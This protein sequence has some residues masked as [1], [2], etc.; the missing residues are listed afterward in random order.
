MSA[1]GDSVTQNAKTTARLLQDARP[2]TAI[3]TAAALG[4][5]AAV[6]R[7]L[8]S[9]SALAQ[10]RTPNGQTP[11]HLAAQWGQLEV[12]RLLLAHGAGAN[13]RDAESRTPLH[14][15][16]GHATRLDLLD[17]LIAHGADPTLSI[18]METRRS[19][20]PP[21]SSIMSATTGARTTGWLRRCSSTALGSMPSLPSSLI[22]T[23]TCA[24]CWLPT[25]R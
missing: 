17:L 2:G 25:R 23:P 15:Q 16:T 11:L 14:A 13:A 1:S 3:F 10:S 8:T 12:A 20:S 24:P 9:N 19:S 18:R 22:A 4:Q 21:A 5:L 6:E 7:A